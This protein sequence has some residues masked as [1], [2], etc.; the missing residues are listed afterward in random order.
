MKYLFC[1]ASGRWLGAWRDKCPD[2]GT[3]SQFNSKTTI[4][5]DLLIQ[6]AFGALGLFLFWLF[7]FR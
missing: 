2:C 5:F 4:L 1:Q 3:F 6:F 7:G